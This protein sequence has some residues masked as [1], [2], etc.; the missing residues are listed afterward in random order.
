MK[1]YI[2]EN[3]DTIKNQLVHQ[4]VNEG[5]HPITFQKI[6]EL[7]FLLYSASLLKNK[8]LISESTYKSMLKDVEQGMSKLI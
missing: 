2:N 7:D 5:T 3:C 6:Y 4:G 1:V 8:D